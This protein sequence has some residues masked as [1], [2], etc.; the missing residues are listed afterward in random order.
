MTSLI[1]QK[2]TEWTGGLEPLEARIALFERVRD[3]PY[4]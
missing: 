3:I 2:Y 1:D 4:S